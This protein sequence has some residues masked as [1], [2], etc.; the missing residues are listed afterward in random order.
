[1]GGQVDSVTV[2]SEGVRV[3]ERGSFFLV[4][5]SRLP[6]WCDGPGC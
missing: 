3:G 6:C 4:A 1:V 5:S 2:L